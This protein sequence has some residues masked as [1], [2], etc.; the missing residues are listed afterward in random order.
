MLT[1]RDDGPKKSETAVDGWLLVSNDDRLRCS[2]HER[3]FRDIKCA[4]AVLLSLSFSDYPPP[5]PPLTMINGN[6]AQ[7]NLM[8]HL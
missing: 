2:P 7:Q 8:C 3:D 6:S 5:P 1:D 4:M